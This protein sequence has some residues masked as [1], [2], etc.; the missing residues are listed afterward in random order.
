MFHAKCFLPRLDKLLVLRS[1][2]TY[3]Y[4][5]VC[6]LKFWFVDQA[7]TKLLE[8]PVHIVQYI[9]IV[10]SIAH[11]IEFIGRRTGK[12]QVCALWVKLSQ[13]ERGSERQTLTK[14]FVSLC[15]TNSKLF[16]QLIYCNFQGLLPVNLVLSF[17]KSSVVVCLIDGLDG[18]N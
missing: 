14:H 5:C 13:E 1:W 4:Q 8:E 16:V 7:Q 6:P 15:W 11:Y 9:A 17:A 2:L 3:F 10:F 18:G 12:S